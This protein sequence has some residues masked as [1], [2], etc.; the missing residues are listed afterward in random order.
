M[1]AKTCRKRNK[2]LGHVQKSLPGPETASVGFW[3]EAIRM[4]TSRVRHSHG[5]LC[6]WCPLELCP[7]QWAMKTMA[8]P[9]SGRG[10][11]RIGRKPGKVRGNQR[12]NGGSG[13][14][15]LLTNHEER[16]MDH[17]R[18]FSDSLHCSCPLMASPSKMGELCLSV[19]SIDQQA[20]RGRQ[21]GGMPLCGGGFLILTPW[22]MWEWKIPSESMPVIMCLCYII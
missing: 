4:P 19:C 2:L 22:W 1:G 20:P 15:R 13:V 9:S 14:C 16:L 5:T 12:I 7:E 6:R 8:D 17:A 21:T 10:S 11:L 18:T 3:A